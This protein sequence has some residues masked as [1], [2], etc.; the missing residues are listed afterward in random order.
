M[1]VACNFQRRSSCMKLS[2]ESQKLR[3]FNPAI[4]DNIRGGQS[5][6][7]AKDFAHTLSSVFCEAESDVWLPVEFSLFRQYNFILCSSRIGIRDLKN[8][9]S[10]PEPFHNRL[11]WGFYSWTMVQCIWRFG[12]LDLRPK[13][14]PNRVN[15][16]SLRDRG[17]L[18]S[19]KNG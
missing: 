5:T 18:V 16:A 1:D 7:K 15:L 8:R 12:C 14:H 6:R 9:S 17:G 13:D 2:Y 11:K 3:K 10:I 19:Y 4:V